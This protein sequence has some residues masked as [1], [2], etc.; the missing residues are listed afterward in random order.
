MNLIS[1]TDTKLAAVHRQVANELERRA[2]IVTTGHDAAAIIYGNEMGKRAVVVA[3]AGDHT[4]LLFGPPNCGKTMMRAVA[5]ELGLSQTFAARP[6]PCGHR[7]SPHRDCSCTARQIE[8][9]SRK[10]LPTFMGG[11]ARVTCTSASMVQPITTASS[12]TPFPL[13]R[14]STPNWPT[15]SG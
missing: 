1:L 12:S 14:D 15:N 8:R 11:F 4:L 7:N 13:V 10:F 6:C 3:A 5:L 9:C 2:R